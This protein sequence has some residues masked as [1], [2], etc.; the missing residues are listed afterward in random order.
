MSS[1][2]SEKL[3]YLV[4]VQTSTSYIVAGLRSANAPG[5]ESVPGS[6]SPAKS[7]TVRVA[8]YTLE[9]EETAEMPD[10]LSTCE[11]AA[12]AG[13]VVLRHWSDKFRVREK[14]PADLVTEADL[15][16]QQ[17]IRQHLL[18]AYP[19]HGF[20]GEE[21]G[22]SVA[23]TSG[24]RWIVDPLDGTT[25]YVHQLPQ[26]CV[27]VALE[28]DGQVLCG[29]VFDPV[30]NE[31]YTAALH[32]GAYLNGVRLRVS[33]TTALESA[34]VAASFPPRVGRGSKSI[35]E[36]IEV[37]LVAQS[38]RRMGSSA[39]NLCYVAAGRLDAYWAN[40]TKIWDVA[41]GVLLVYEAGGV[42]T[43][44]DGGPLNL[45]QPKFIAA[46]NSDLRQ[47]LSS[48]LQASAG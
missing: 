6:E 16:S 30:S 29:T 21:A 27:S 24:Y 20:L 48:R 34:L 11:A 37:L 38:V 17:V 25:N 36:F 39:L 10:F 42:V 8:G 5:S 2:K 1:T 40:D 3:S 32:Q 41:A 15:A 14:G 33:N 26:Y 7:S 22:D 4:C 9:C 23:G 46:A 47:A 12:R 13:G 18:A 45:E 19:E 35:G 31:C 44:R 43:A 28:K